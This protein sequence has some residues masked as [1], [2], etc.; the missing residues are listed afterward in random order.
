VEIKIFNACLLAGWLMVTAGAMVLSFGAGLCVGG[1][2]LIALT[3]LI[4]KV[5]GLVSPGKG[6]V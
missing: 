3:L 2:L 4:A 5:G 1:A 6:E